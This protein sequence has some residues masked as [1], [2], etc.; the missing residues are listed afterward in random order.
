MKSYLIYLVL[1]SV[2]IISCQK[3]FFNEDESRRELIFK[4][5]HAV[6]I[7]GIY[8]IVLIQDSANRLVITGKNDINSI[9]AVIINDTLIIDDHKKM[10]LNPAKN[11]LALHFSNLR[12]MVTNDPVNVSNTDTIKADRFIYDAIGEIA[13]VSLVVDCNYLLVVNSANTLGYFYL[14][15]KAN[16]YSF[17]NRYGCSIFADNL[18][19]KNAE[20]TNESV[21]D[22]YINASENITAFIWGPGNIYYHGT[23]VIQIAEKRGTGRIIRLD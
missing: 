13:E 8:N 2:F 22:V 20:I 12:Y 10:S 21:G 4:D 17:F 18:S 14:S 16:D 1:A 7:S 15:G 23:P 19:G 9:D 5:F 6:K 11:T 3:I